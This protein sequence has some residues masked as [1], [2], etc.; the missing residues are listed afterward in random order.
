[1]CPVTSVCIVYI[2]SFNLSYESF[3]KYIKN[4]AFC[5]IEQTFGLS[6]NDKRVKII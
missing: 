3:F 6:L 4:I 5:F 1:M 2:Q